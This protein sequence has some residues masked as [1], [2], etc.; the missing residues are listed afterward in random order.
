M[1]V[2]ICGDT[3]RV[4]TGFARCTRVAA[5]SLLAAGHDVAVLGISEDGDPQT[6]NDGWGVQRAFDYPIYPARNMRSSRISNWMGLDRIRPMVDYLKPDIVVLLNDPWN[7]P[8]YLRQLRDE[9]DGPTVV[10]VVGWLAVDSDNHPH[11]AELNGLA[12]VIVWTKYAEQQ[13]RL[14]GCDRQF[15]VV[16]LGV[17]AELYQPMSRD[18]ARDLVMPALRDKFVVGMVGRNQP[19]KRLD[20]AMDA[21]ARW[22]R[23]RDVKDAVLFMHVAPTGEKSCDLRALAQHH[24]LIG[25]VVVT[26]TGD[27]GVGFCEE[28]LRAVY[29]SFDVY[30]T[31][32]QGEGWGLTTHEAMACGVPCVVPD[33]SALGEWPGGAVLKVPCSSTAL[34]A[35]LNSMPYTIGGIADRAALVAALDALYRNPEMRTEYSCLGYA[36]AR[37]PQFS[38]ASIGRRIVEVLEGVL[39]ASDAVAVV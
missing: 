8:H 39:E 20:L 35:P 26:D 31:T 13:L 3:P 19:R 9:E 18:D 27:S 24:R 14:G 21:F 6:A 28:L 17:N 38:W 34:T 7:V 1:R 22:T 4:D 16:P 10:P 37:E 36:K 29:C 33:W 25:R 11:S 30:L 15:S 2:L 23:E 32:T 12:H 5:A